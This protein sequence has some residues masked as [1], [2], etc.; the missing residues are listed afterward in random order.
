MTNSDILSIQLYSLRK[1]GDLNRALDLVASIGFK[2]VEPVMSHYDD[3]A[4]TRAALDERGLTAPSG[5]FSLEAVSE[6][7]GW[8]ID[9]AKTIGIQQIIVPAVPTE[10]RTSRAADW[11]ATTDAMASAAPALAD[12]GLAL[13]Y[14]N[15][16][17]DLQPTD[18]GP[19]PL[20]IILSAPDLKWQADVAWIARAGVPV[21]D[22]LSKY[23]DRLISCHVKD[24]APAG[25]N[26][27]E[28]GWS[29]VGDGV[30]DWKTLWSRCRQT[31][32]D[33]MV[34]E[35]DNPRDFEPFVKRSFAF[36]QGLN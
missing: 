10:V 32:A 27:D 24:I 29:A 11:H 14:H 21:N 20:D 9:V 18:E 8:V 12:A 25:E 4:G 31:P 7:T 3:A 6:R 28:D 1:Y 30:M 26:L 17:W 23:E 19:T 36:L 15:H 35:H 5:H 22:W 2:Q 16:D 33:W 34:V 13:A